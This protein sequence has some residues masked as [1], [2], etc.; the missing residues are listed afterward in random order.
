MGGLG[1]VLFTTSEQLVAGDADSQPDLY[2]EREGQTS[3]VSTGTEDPAAPTLSG[4][5][6]GSPANAN[7][8]AVQ[9]T[10]P[11]GSE[12]A[13]FAD[14]QCTGLPKLTGSA[15]TLAGAGLPISVG[16]DTSTTVYAAAT[17]DNGNTSPCS[18]GLTYVE[19]S[20]ATPPTLSAVQPTGPANDNAPRV[21]GSAETGASVRIFSDPLCS[22]TPLA[23][24]TEAELADPG[25]VVAVPDNAT[26]RFF[27]TI[28]D[29]A[30]NTSLCSEASPAYVED[31]LAPTTTISGGPRKTTHEK[32]SVF[33]L[34]A[35][36]TATFECKVDNRGFR[37]CSSPYKTPGLRFGKSHRLMVKAT[38]LAGNVEA[39]PATRAF[40]VLKKPPKRH[41]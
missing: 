37:P 40:R 26:T 25:V 15:A 36:E 28:D 20:T 16:N 18:A 4:T 30:G 41:R 31:S 39:T 17:D 29:S 1:Q 38:D 33:Q 12:V 22:G 2:A 9:G 11:A 8:P 27:A 10:A 32:R 7:A 35:D 13:L 19:D 3:L 24:A 5:S 34:G 21:T 6:P 14:A 23:T